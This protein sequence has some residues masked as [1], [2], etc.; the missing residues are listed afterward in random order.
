MFSA[1]S[2][3]TFSVIKT[4]GLL[5]FLLHGLRVLFLEEVCR[6]ATETIK[7]DFART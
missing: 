5:Q 2:E 4:E 1:Y 3:F 6:N 7:V